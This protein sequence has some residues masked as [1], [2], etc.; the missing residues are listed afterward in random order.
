MIA[1]EAALT[2]LISLF[3]RACFR[4]YT[5]LNP[6]R[7]LPAPDPT[8]TLTPLNHTLTGVGGKGGL[9]TYFPEGAASAALVHL[10]YC[11]S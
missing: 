2:G 9:S 5:F 3:V 6:F 1:V 8:T 11:Y 7:V 4:R 10:L